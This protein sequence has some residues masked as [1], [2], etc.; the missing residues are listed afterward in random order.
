MCRIC[1]EEF[2]EK[3]GEIFKME[4]SCWGEMVLVYKDCVFKWF[5]I[6][7]NCICDVCGFEVCN[8]LVMV[9]C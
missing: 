4:C 3:Y 1:F 7:G 5:S 2:F 9:V 6:K 8:L